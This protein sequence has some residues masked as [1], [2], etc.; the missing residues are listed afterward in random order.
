M[1]D[2]QN[3]RK[4]ASF[5]LYGQ[6]IPGC[7]FYALDNKIPHVAVAPALSNAAIITIKDH[8]ISSRTLLNELKLWDDGGWDWQ[9]R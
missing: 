9:I 8:K 2:C 6:G 4:P 1:V 5:K 7:S 3:R